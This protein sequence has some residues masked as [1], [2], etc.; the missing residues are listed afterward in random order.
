MRQHT[1]EK[2]KFS[3]DVIKII[4]FIICVIFLVAIIAFVCDQCGKA[5]TDESNFNQH[6]KSRHGD[7]ELL[8]WKCDR[9]EKGFVNKSALDS[10][11]YIEKLQIASVQFYL[12]FLK[13]KCLVEKRLYQGI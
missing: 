13:V 5:F 4:S 12:F 7:P 9:C 6:M 10:H 8:K 1:G 11:M 3:K 2:R